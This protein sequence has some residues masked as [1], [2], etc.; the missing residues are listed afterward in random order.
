MSNPETLSHNF[1][2]DLF[3]GKNHQVN[4]PVLQILGFEIS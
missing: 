1:L 2:L 4:Q 3:M